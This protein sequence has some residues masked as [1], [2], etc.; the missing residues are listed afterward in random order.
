MHRRSLMIKFY[1]ATVISLLSI[2]T[3]SHSAD[4]GEFLT[5]VSSSDIK[6]AQAVDML[7]NIPDHGALCEAIKSQEFYLKAEEMKLG[8]FKRNA[9][10]K[11][12][13]SYVPPKQATEVNSLDSDRYPKAPQ[14]IE[15]PQ[16]EVGRLAV[17]PLPEQT[18]EVTI[19]KKVNKI[20][21][22]SNFLMQD[23]NA[24]Q[25][26]KLE[27]TQR[28]IQEITE[29]LNSD[30]STESQIKLAD[31]NNKFQ[32]AKENYDNMGAIV[33]MLREDIEKL[34]SQ[35]KMFQKFNPPTH[36]N[37]SNEQY[38][39]AILDQIADLKQARQVNSEEAIDQLKIAKQRL[40]ESKADLE[41]ANRIIM[42]LND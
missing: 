39:T 20:V 19:Q 11:Y 28:A 30:S 27:E 36:E 13:Q 38:L 10:V 37:D 41:E 3:A 5:S 34:H 32:S 25:E 40:D 24:T 7:K 23:I 26:S 21:I 8:L 17:N 22:P 35:Y 18:E 12:C 42:S 29:Q 2:S 9:L 14:E 15:R 6:P 31:A 1:T 4:L 33:K 16:N